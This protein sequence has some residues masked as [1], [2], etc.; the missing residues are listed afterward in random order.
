MAVYRQY[1]FRGGHG[2]AAKLLLTLAGNFAGAFGTALLLRQT[3]AA[4]NLV[5]RAAEL[6]AVKLQDEPVSVFILAVF[7]GVLMYIGVNGFG[8][9]ELALGKYAAV[10]LAVAV[11]ILS[12]FEHCVANMF[13]YSLA[14][15][16][17]SG[18]AWLSMAVMVLGNSAGSVV[19]AEGYRA[20]QKLQDAA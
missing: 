4:A 9:F 2:Y 12:G 6:S 1:L 16:W 14:G 19:V 11:F 7:C 20:A 15:V 8:V 5:G 13:Y 3:R 10:F 18:Q 17:D